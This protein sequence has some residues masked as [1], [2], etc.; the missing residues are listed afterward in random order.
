MNDSLESTQSVTEDQQPIYSSP[1][2]L[3][4]DGET[5]NPPPEL[6]EEPYFK[7][8]HCFFDQDTKKFAKKVYYV[9]AGQIKRGKLYDRPPYLTRVTPQ[10]KEIIKQDAAIMKLSPRKLEEFFRPASGGTATASTRSLE[11]NQIREDIDITPEVEVD[12]D[13][14]STIAVYSSPLKTNEDAATSPIKSSVMPNEDAATSPIIQSVS[15]ILRTDEGSVAA[16]C[17]ERIYGILTNHNTDFNV[18]KSSTSEE[19]IDI[20]RTRIQLEVIV[21]PL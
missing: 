7:Y 6:G 4:S 1:E 10:K 2:Q 13:A 3:R 11:I 5:L 12:S 21:E 17:A 20:N 18:I 16:L 19:K 9:T 15:S 8:T 14:A